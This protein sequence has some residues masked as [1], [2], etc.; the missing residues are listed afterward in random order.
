METIDELVEG[1]EY[2]INKAKDD[3][4][5]VSEMDYLVGTTFIYYG[6]KMTVG[7]MPTDKRVMVDGWHIKPQCLS[8]VKTKTAKK[9]LIKQDIVVPETDKPIK[10]DGGSSGYYKLKMRLSSDNVSKVPEHD[11]LVDIELET[12]DVIRAL[13]DNDFDLGNMVKAIRRIHQASKGQGKDNTT[14]EYDCNKIEY[15]L[16]EWYNNYQ[17]EQI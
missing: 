1:K 11:E 8:E 2:K 6:E 12:G 7:Y 4:D 14:V 15:F 13:V 3:H 9:K 16:K 10:S 17:K 5:W